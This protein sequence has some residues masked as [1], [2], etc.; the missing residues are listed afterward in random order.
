MKLSQIITSAVLACVVA[1]PAFAL[2]AKKSIHVDASPAAAWKEIGDFCG[3]ADWHPAVAKCSISMK[4]KVMLR[5]LDL[6]GGGTIIEKQVSRSDAKHKY[7]YA[8]VESPLP[9]DH[10]KSTISVKKSGKGSTI[11]W[12]GTFMAK[13]APDE[14]A[15]DVIGGIY[16]GGLDSLQKKLAQ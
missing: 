5:T 10:Y 9:V 1:S 14:K 4:D 13:G 3:I 6:N 2:E 15:I 16:Q 12:S 8:I 11:V 7:T